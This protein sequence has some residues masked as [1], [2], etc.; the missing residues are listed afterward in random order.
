MRDSS[1][2][3]TSDTHTHAHT[4]ADE[5]KEKK[6]GHNTQRDKRKAFGWSGCNKRSHFR[7]NKDGGWT[8][9][10]GRA[11]AHVTP[12]PLFPML[13]VGST[14]TLRECLP[15]VEMLSQCN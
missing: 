9:F 13:G 5:Q 7:G 1:A 11:H 6:I 14:Q 3:E 12:Q 8:Y 10:R 2:F 4:W 15:A